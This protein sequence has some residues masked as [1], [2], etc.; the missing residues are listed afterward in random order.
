MPTF[1]TAPSSN[2]VGSIK[3]L[4]ASG[5]GQLSPLQEVQVDSM[6][7]QT[8]HQRA[9]T[10]HQQSLAEK[11]RAEYEQ[12]Q[13]AQRDR[14]DPNLTTRYAGDVAGFDEPTSM[15]LAAHLRGDMEEPAPGDIDDAAAMGLDAQP[16]RTAAPNV[17]DQGR[18]L[19]QAARAAA[20]GTRLATDKTNA[21][22]LAQAGGELQGQGLLDEVQRRIAAGDYQGASA[23]SQGSKPG[24]AIRLHDNIGDTGATFAPATGAVAANP[25]ADP[26][27]QLL[28]STLAARAADAARDRAAAEASRAQAEKARREPAEGGKPPPGYRF[29]PDGSLEAIPGGPAD[30]KAGEAGK[31]DAARLAIAKGKADI[32]IGAV[33][34]ALDQTGFFTTGFIG[35][36]LGKIPG[37]SAYDLRKTATTIKANIGFQELQAMREASPT[38]GALG[39]VAVQ[40]LESLQA[41]L[42]SID[43]D[44]STEQL[45]ENLNKVKTHYENWKRTVE[46]AN[47]VESPPAGEVQSRKKIGNVEFVKINGV[48]HTP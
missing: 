42:A 12:M 17:S 35:A 23:V 33:D 21:L 48:W 7:A 16:Y 46:K 32:V 34:K 40:E 44:Q 19:F 47:G 29:K 41:V 6:A 20:T 5:G 37:T 1:R 30:A 45:T 3:R 31:K 39:Q 22:Q 27:N 2:L 26:T 36:N 8:A 11:V 9:Q 18:R 10:E 38:G 24:T 15:R 25:A 4:M 14:N 13:A 28:P 43:A